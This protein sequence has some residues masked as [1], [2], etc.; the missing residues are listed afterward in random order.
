VC[1]YLSIPKNSGRA[2][3]APESANNAAGTSSFIPLFSLGIPGSATSAIILG[4]F[5]MHGLQP[6]PLMMTKQP[7]LVY[8]IIASLFL[9]N[10]LMLIMCKPLIAAFVHT[11]KVPYSILAPLIFVF[12]FIG[13]YTSRNT[14]FDIWVML[15]FGVLGYFLDKIKFPLAPIILGVVLGPMAE[16]E[17]R[18]SLLMSGGDYTIF[19]TRPICL[20]LLL[21]TVGSLAFGLYNIYYKRDEKLGQEQ[22]SKQA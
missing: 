16:A 5:I 10:V 14:L 17:F 11:Q 6:G 15:F 9:I 2:V 18:R 13:T 1:A 3:A 7:I 20:I 4:A 8:T 22:L 21:I 19:V 12:C